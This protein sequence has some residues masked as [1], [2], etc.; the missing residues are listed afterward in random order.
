VRGSGEVLVSHTVAS[1]PRF[2]LSV[3]FWKAKF[4]AK[5]AQEA[6]ARKCMFVH[7]DIFPSYHGNLKHSRDHKMIDCIIEELLDTMSV[8]Y[9]FHPLRQGEDAL[10]MLRRGQ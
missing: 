3:A 5:A 1:L 2:R 8:R 9:P 10:S 4:L 7:G 6:S